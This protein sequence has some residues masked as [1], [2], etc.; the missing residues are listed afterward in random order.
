[1]VRLIPRICGELSIITEYQRC[2]QVR[3][4]KHAAKRA[5]N[6]IWRFTEYAVNEGPDEMAQQKNP[7]QEL[8]HGPTDMLR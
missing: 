8:P 4:P 3:I 1:M 2:H 6:S 5:R 7:L